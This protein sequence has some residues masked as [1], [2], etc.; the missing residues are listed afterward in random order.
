VPF[1]H[2]AGPFS[3]MRLVPCGLCRVKW[4]P[5]VMLSTV[6]PPP[7]LPVTGSG[8][9]IEARV[10]KSRGKADSRESDASLVGEQLIFLEIEMHRQLL[11]K[12]KV[13]GMNAA[14]ALKTQ[15]QLGPDLIVG[16][17]RG[18]AA[19]RQGGWGGLMHVQVS[20]TAIHTPALPPPAV[21]KIRRSIAVVDVEDQVLLDL[22]RRIEALALENRDRLL[23]S[24][25]AEAEA[26]RAAVRQA[27]SSH[28]RVMDAQAEELGWRLVGEKVAEAA[29]AAARERLVFGG[30]CVSLATPLTRALRPRA[31]RGR[32]RGRLPTGLAQPAAR[33][34]PARARGQGSEWQQ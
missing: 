3:N 7:L 16:V 19:P 18:P 12:L 20:A 1:K 28:T 6:E 24:A 21:L 2:N 5:E 26:V 13:M 4:V 27:Q 15:I 31:R 25:V 33:Q 11:L 10:C 32:R 23:L 9:L 30:A 8:T 14:F 17:V 22:Q 34:A 29:A